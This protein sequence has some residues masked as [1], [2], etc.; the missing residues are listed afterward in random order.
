MIARR[1]HANRIKCFSN[2]RR[3]CRGL[4]LDK[5]DINPLASCFVRVSGGGWYLDVFLAVTSILVYT[6][7]CGRCGRE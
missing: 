2:H 1:P 7:A 5:I 4:E 3:V 6:S